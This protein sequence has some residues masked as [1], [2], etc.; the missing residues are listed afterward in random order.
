MDQGETRRREGRDEEAGG[1]ETG[2]GKENTGGR[3]REERGGRE[4]REDGERRG[5]GAQTPRNK[6]IINKNETKNA[7][8]SSITSATLKNSCVSRLMAAPPDMAMRSLVGRRQLS[9]SHEW[10]RKWGCVKIDERT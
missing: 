1:G 6:V 8:C 9:S 7:P 4:Q 10:S 5:K 3:G 2:K